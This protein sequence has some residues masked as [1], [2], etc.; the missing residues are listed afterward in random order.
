MQGNIL[1]IRRQ[2]N[3]ATLILNRPDKKNSLSPQ[4][5]NKLRDALDDLA[6]DAARYS[7]FNHSRRR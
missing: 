5:V 7:C 4:L 3:I 2:G 6:A 1:S